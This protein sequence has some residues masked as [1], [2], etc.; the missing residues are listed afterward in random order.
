MACGILVPGPGIEA[1][2][3]NCKCGVLATGPPGKSLN[4]IL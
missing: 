2:L 3:Q 1:E 4:L